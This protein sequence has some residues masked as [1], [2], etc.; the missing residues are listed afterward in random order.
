MA[1]A[2]EE[3]HAREGPGRNLSLVSGRRAAAV[4][5]RRRVTLALRPGAPRRPVI[6]ELFDAASTASETK[7]V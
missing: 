3:R 1:A 2:M 4:G 7:A 6:L 5:E